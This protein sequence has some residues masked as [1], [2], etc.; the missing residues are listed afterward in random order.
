MFNKNHNILKEVKTV[1]LVR[2][3]VLR[4]GVEQIIVDPYEPYN[5][6]TEGPCI[7]LIVTD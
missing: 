3:L 4:E 7:I 1:D 6:T 5:L 2:E